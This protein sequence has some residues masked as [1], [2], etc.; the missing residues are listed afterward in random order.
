M[1]VS[2][3][4]YLVA[5][6]LAFLVPAGLVLIGAA[7]ID[8][9]RSWAAALAG[10]AAIGLAG[11]GYWAVGF[12][13][14]FGGIGLFYSDPALLGLVLEW[15]ALPENWG[16]GW[17]MAGLSGWFL[18]GDGMTP[19]A[20][21]L[22]LAHLPWAATAALLP[23]LALRGRAPAVAALVL[24]LGSGAFLYPLAGNWV[25]G[26]GWLAALGRNVGAGHGMVDFGGAGTV[27]LVAAGTT[28]ASLLVW[29][30]RHSP[31]TLS[32]PNL[33]TVHL[34]MLA[35]VGALLLPVGILGWSWANPIQTGIIGELGPLRGSVNGILFV[36]SG[37]LIPVL[38]TWFVTGESDPMMAA[39]GMAA[40]A[41]AGLGAGPFV[42]PTV[43]LVI[44]LMAGGSVPFVTFAANRLLR[45]NDSAG[46]IS[47]TAIPALLGLLGLG[48]FADG[49]VGSG[50][51]MTGVGSYLG[52]TGQGVTGLFAASG[53]VAD[54]PGQL[55][56]QVIG[57]VA[58]LL[59]GFVTGSLICIPLAA[60]AQG[61]DAAARH[62]HAQQTGLR[63]DTPST[64]TEQ[65]NHSPADG[66]EVYVSTPILSQWQEQEIE[67]S[68]RSR[69]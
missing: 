14:Q 10:L 2:N 49:S 4:W 37:S 34:P 41:I 25:Q 1:D 11:M 5:A 61:L 54:F 8:P 29:L 67:Q 22:F 58:L 51:Q 45:L 59:W 16:R 44:G 30:P 53:F 9:Q 7:G 28:A 21:A 68:R 55:Q 56:A 69:G 57:A 39:R 35:V 66:G 52:V 24:A 62:G 26:G 46:I 33:P 6:G 47:M 42:T 13:L 38:Y 36:I 19:A 3:Y 63:G 43:A 32:D 60:L 12:A 48:L 23:V 20:F 15:S 18:S 64:P 31:R 50:W 27:F 40:G 65:Y 17:G